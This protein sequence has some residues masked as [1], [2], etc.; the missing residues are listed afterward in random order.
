MK[1]YKVKRKEYNIFDAVDISFNVAPVHSVLFILLELI[2]NI[3]VPV[4][5]YISAWFIDSAKAYVV[6]SGPMESVVNALVM[7][8]II[9][10]IDWTWYAVRVLLKTCIYNRMQAAFFVEIASKQARLKYCYIENNDIWDLIQRVTGNPSSIGFMPILNDI[11]S[12]TGF[13]IK[14]LGVLYVLMVNVWWM[15][16]L[17]VALSIPALV[18]SYKGGKASYEANKAMSVHERRTAYFGDILTG[19][20]AASERTLFRYSERINTLWEKNYKDALKIYFVTKLK[21]F[22]RQRLS[23]ISMIV[24]AFFIMVILLKPTL[25]GTISIG[26]YISLISA[27]VQISFKMQWM[28]MGRLESLARGVEYC[29]DF[30]R[31][32]HLEEV[33][34]VTEKPGRI[35][36]FKSLEFKDVYFKYPGTEQYIL[37]GISFKILPDR[38]YAIVGANGS[39][40]STI[41]KLMMR[42]YE[43]DSG[44]ILI[45]GLSI[46]KYSPNDIAGFLSV[47]HQDFAKYA[48]SIKDNIFLGDVNRPLSNEEANRIIKQVNLEET[49]KRLPN[50]IETKLGKLD[51]DSVDLSGGEWQKIALSRALRSP[52][53]LQI[54][55]EPTAALSPLA[56]AA[57]YREYGELSQGKTTLFISH[58]LGSTK[59]ADEIF[60]VSDGVISEQGSHETLMRTSGGYNN[61]YESQRKWYE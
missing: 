4:S 41:I 12:F 56:E 27:T 45:N 30:T 60:V 40:K 8:L 16:I 59:L 20:D 39:G 29:K 48:L 7:L 37:K 14:V 19:R 42:L 6:G 5:I 15:T 47:V 36:N 52:G 13:C 38:H 31:F 23:S 55:D 50:K 51:D 1:T 54:L 26:M 61:M 3:I 44:E 21:W 28:F 10:G 58:R 33:E 9:Y 24:L 22:I 57:I 43:V 18:I 49:V 25:L 2:G 11:V 17:I 35:K 53:P 32:A 34:G 46:Q